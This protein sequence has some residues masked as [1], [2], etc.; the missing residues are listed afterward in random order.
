MAKHLKQFFCQTCFKIYTNKM[1]IFIFEISNKT[2]FNFAL[3]KVEKQLNNI[4]IFC[5]DVNFFKI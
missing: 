4:L 2:F 3:L 5:I 1:A